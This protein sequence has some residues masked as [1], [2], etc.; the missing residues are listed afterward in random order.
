M[1]SVERTD[2]ASIAFLGKLGA[3]ALDELAPRARQVRA[4]A[5]E[6]LVRAGDPAGTVFALAQGRLQVENEVGTVLNEL[7][8][9]ALVGEVT[10]LV[11]GLRTASVRA[12]QDSELFEL[13]AAALRRV[14][15]ADPERLREL[16]DQARHGLRRSQF[17]RRLMELAGGLDP[18]ALREIEREVEWRSVRGGEALFR[19]GEPAGGA[20][21]LISGRLRVSMPEPGG[22]R[23]LGE[24][25]PG[26]TV[27]ELG[28]LSGEPRTATVVAVRDSEL[29]HLSDVSFRA[30]IGRHPGA[31]RQVG[32]YLV[33]RLGAQLARPTR[34]RV[35]AVALLPAAPDVEIEE[36]SAELR[37]AF[38]AFGTV[39]LLSSRSVDAELVRK[40]IAQAKAD[41]PADT[42]LSHWLGE[43]EVAHDF[44]LYEADTHPTPWSSRCLRQADHVVLLAD[45]G[46]L[47][48]EAPAPAPSGAERTL[49]LW[50]AQRSEGA[51]V[52]ARWLDALGI[53]PAFHVRAR[54][55]DTARLARLLAARAVGLVLAGGGAR[56]FANIGVL[57]ALEELEVPIDLIGGTSLGAVVA[58]GA[59]RGLGSAQVLE[60]CR[61]F[62]TRLFDPALP[63]AALLAGP[64]LREA[65]EADFGEQ[66]IED[67]PTPYFCVSTRAAPEPD[68]VH[69]RG[70]LRHAVH[71]SLSL[72]GVLGR[73]GEEREM[74]LDDGLLNHVPA[75]EMARRVR[76]GAVIASDASLLGS[77]EPV[78]AATLYLRLPVSGWSAR[79]LGSVD[80]I[81]ERGYAAAIEPLRAW[82]R[83]TRSAAPRR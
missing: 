8:P 35:R 11:G 33:E 21:L 43:L 47:P 24:L 48:G 53:S 45:A 23:A 79:E 72:P 61:R 39:R 63:S 67:L 34:S 49:A 62:Y 60:V 25:S 28:L 27:G 57:R 80:A 75:A 77:R 78:G 9:G 22:E 83:E 1:T 5:G 6:L 42:R 54:R 17:A 64:R 26:E 7:E 20:Y 4:A 50:H 30:M 58:A 71:A 16:A 32:R 10:L 56:G 69:D 40:G 14:L 74:V 70:R 44:V 31:L 41:D 68:V 2:L 65:L 3:E 15:D 46:R 66:D 73:A 38:A 19:A 29:A 36:F 59:A 76:G 13:D 18:G 55:G 51:M 82:W 81:A 37:R 12:L 52:T